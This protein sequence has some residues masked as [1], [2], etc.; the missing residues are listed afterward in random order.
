MCIRDSSSW[1]WADVNP[2]IPDNYEAVD[3]LENVYRVTSE[4]GTVKYYRYIRNEDDTFAFVEVDE[5]GN[6]IEISIPKAD[7]IPEN[8]AHI[9]GNIY[10]VCNEHGVII[11]Y[12]E[13]ISN[14]DGD[15]Y[16]RQLQHRYGFLRLVVWLPLTKQLVNGRLS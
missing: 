3:G 5:N 8:Y 7:E 16:K 10:A 9:S 13:R 14:E 4:D 6:D 2:D 1:L 12:M 15:V 11:G